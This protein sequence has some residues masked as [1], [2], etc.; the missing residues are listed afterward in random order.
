MYDILE[1]LDH[2]KKV[3]GF[4]IGGDECAICRESMNEYD[5]ENPLYILPECKHVYHVNC[6]IPWLRESGESQC[7]Y[8]KKDI[9]KGKKSFYQ[10]VNRLEL[11][12][13]YARRVDANPKVK[14][15]YEMYKKLQNDYVESKR[16]RNV[17]LKENKPIFHEYDRLKL[18]VRRSWKRFSNYRTKLQ[19]IAVTP[20]IM[21]FKEN[22]P[23]VKK[24]MKVK[25][26]KSESFFVM[27]SEHD[28]DEFEDV[29]DEE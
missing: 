25:K 12:K 6:Y 17:F 13:N 14:K 28:E 16:V 19:N 9:E 7:P 22:A 5:L 10:R 8:C 20:V 26:K 15:M 21:Y 18:K 11:I 27:N 24:Y 29:E 1:E 23:I 2:Q 3:Y 4:E